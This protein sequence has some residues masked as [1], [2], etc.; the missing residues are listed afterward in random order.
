MTETFGQML[1]NDAL[2][3]D[4]RLTGPVTKKA[5]SEALS[6]Y[7]KKDPQGYARAI[8]DVKKVGDDIST[9]EGISVGLDDIAPDYARRDPI[10]KSAL[11]QMK[12]ATTDADKR[13]ILLETQDKVLATVPHHKSDMTLMARS[14]G[15]GSMAQLMKTVAS[16]VV[17]SSTD[18]QE[19]PWLITKSYSQGL[20][21]AD[22]WVTGAESRRNAIASTG[23]V[24]EPGAVA[25]VVVSNMENLVIT[26]PDCK[27]RGGIM[28]PIGAQAVDRYLAR[29]EA[30]HMA[31]DLITPHV[32]SD[33]KKSKL[34]R[35]MVR[36]PATC[37]ADDGI[38]QKCMGLNEWGNPYPIGSNVGVRSAQ[39]LTEPLTQFALNAKHGVRMA[40][41]KSRALSGLD[42]FRTLT[43]VPKS[44][45]DKA[46]ISEM[47][48]TVSSVTK[49]PQG[50][51][52]IKVDAKNYYVPPG[53]QPIVKVNDRVEA[54]D[55]LSDGTP[56]PNDVVRLKGVGAGRQY[57]ADS[58]SDLY[59]RQGVDLDRRHAELLARSS[60]NY[61]RVD[62][63]PTNTF[64]RGDVVAFKDM[65]KAFGKHTERVPVSKAKNMI[66]GAPAMHY[67]VGTRVTSRVIEDLEKAGIKDIEVSTKSPEFEPI[68]KSIIQTPLLSDDWMSRLSHRYL[69][70]TLVDGAGF[71]HTTNVASTSPVPAFAM[72]TPF[73]TGQD[74]K[75]ASAQ[76]EYESA[77]EKLASAG[78]LIPMAKKFLFGAPGA[79][80]SA[81]LK[82]IST[83]GWTQGGIDQSAH[84]ARRMGKGM[85]GVDW[86]SA[87]VTRGGVVTDEGANALKSIQGM[88]KP[89]L[90][91][92]MSNSLQGVPTPDH[93][94][95]AAA[96]DAH[97]PGLSQHIT[98]EKFKAWNDKNTT[99]YRIG[100][101][102]FQDMSIGQSPLQVLK[103]RYQHGGVIGKGGLLTGDFAVD[104]DTARAWREFNKTK[105]VERNGKKYRVHANTTG[106]RYM[107][108]GAAVGSEALQ[109]SFTIGLPAASVYTA[110]T[111]PAGEGESR[112]G[113]VGSAIGETAG[114]G[115][116]SPAG[117]L[118]GWAIATPVIGAGRAIGEKLDPDYVPASP[119]PVGA[120]LH[121]AAN[122]SLD[123]YKYMQY[124][125]NAARAAEA[126]KHRYYQ[127]QQQQQSG[128]GRPPTQH[129][130]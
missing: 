27:T 24:V 87:G 114:W 29:A 59:G 79:L 28:L 130:G 110:A 41:G 68:M 82:H 109:K 106:E 61:V 73:G 108:L 18:G 10:L 76:D 92:R 113:N 9:L 49:A 34:Y 25:K 12:K 46:S 96:L 125:S 20:S 104:P 33:L 88:R 6:A 13:K 83:K 48:G 52:N 112:L 121:N 53:L 101:G 44:F 84:L 89:G 47:D 86:E 123:N 37:E 90:W 22:A 98:P 56:M 127:Q 7:A 43:E 31:G 54:G 111:T 95:D 11:S 116:G 80:D 93:K 3:G 117:F 8:Q 67:S 62:K 60:M 14:G 45:M 94:Y 2:P 57:M 103:Q 51:W 70:K 99:G 32:L 19:V 74:G 58:I 50:G 107:G 102:V 100:K 97:I 72:G 91:D 69:R 38:C 78:K 64:I 15:R 30:S 128:Y 71:G 115:L 55:A 120:R 17:A 105:V 39:A 129:Y 77:L 1:L 65:Q 4:M 124:Y 122:S 36:S 42:G 63:D 75:Y 85:G 35:I 66:L 118:G 23:S 16:P 5:L 119:A 81:P 26:I 126:A 21:A 40:G